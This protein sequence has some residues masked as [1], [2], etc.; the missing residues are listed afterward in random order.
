MRERG[1]TDLHV[2]RCGLFISAENPWLAAS[3]DGLVTDPAD[4][5]SQLEIKNPYSPTVAEA[6]ASTAFCLKKNENGTYP[7]KPRHDYNYQIQCQLYC[8]QRDWCDFVVRTG[9]DIH[10]ERVLRNASWFESNLSKMKKFRF[11][12]MLPELACPRFRK[13]CIREITM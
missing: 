4:G 9:K 3:P 10:T 7:L 8:T 11:N 1:H 2:K 12:C 13:G 6:A 5:I